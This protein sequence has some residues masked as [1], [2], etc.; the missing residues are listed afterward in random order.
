AG[1]ISS[2]EGE[3]LMIALDREI[4]PASAF[5]GVSYRNLLVLH[6]AGGA[7]T[8]PPHDIVGQ[9]IT[10][11]LPTGADAPLLIRCMEISR[12]V[13]ADH[14]V[15]RDRISRGL[16]PASQIWPWS[17]GKS[18]ALPLFWDK[19]GKKGGII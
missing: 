2:G 16:A 12:E 15:N 18:P 14:P 10:P 19:Y 13:F 4:S 9:D 3:A 7:V 17:G 6:D 11:H 5:P 8:V 1:H